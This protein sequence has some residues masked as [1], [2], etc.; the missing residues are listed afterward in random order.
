MYPSTS[1]TTGYKL[2][3]SK[4][5]DFVVPDSCLSTSIQVLTCLDNLASC[6]DL[7]VCPA[8]SPLRQTPPP[9][10]HIHIKDLEVTVSLYLQSETL[11]FLTPLNWSLTSPTEVKLSSNFVFAS[12]QTVLPP[13]RPGRGSGFFKQ[14]QY[15]VIIPKSYIL[16][17]AFMLLYV[18]DWEKRIG[19]FSM[20]MIAYIEQYVD[21][22][23]FLE[24][25]LLTEP[26]L[27]F[28]KE[29]KKGG[30]PLRQWTEELKEAVGILENS[31]SEVEATP[32]SRAD[33]K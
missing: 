30:K 29:L 10:F 28:Y 32:M 1:D 21:E 25:E 26:L 17:E 12:D 11:W 22:D 8:S 4:S 13:W 3:Y 16:L 6:P 24:T 5:I 31:R 14:G 33:F 15:P 9:T 20:A 2:I 7:T 23:G 19:D 27:T 18:R